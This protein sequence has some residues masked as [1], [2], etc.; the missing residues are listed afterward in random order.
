MCIREQ[1]EGSFFFSNIEA[2]DLMFSYLWINFVSLQYWR[3][4]RSYYG[5]NPLFYH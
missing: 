5:K 1:S 3:E 2:K 4:G